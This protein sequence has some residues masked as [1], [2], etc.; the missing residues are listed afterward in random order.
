MGQVHNELTRGL[1]SAALTAALGVAKGRGGLERFG[2]TLQPTVNLWERPEWAFLR[3]EQL[4][5]VRQ[6]QGAVAGEL[7]HVAIANPVDSN[8]ISVITALEIRGPVAAAVLNL[9]LFYRGTWTSSAARG[10]MALQAALP[11]STDTRVQPSGVVRTEVWSGSDVASQ[12][13]AQTIDFAS[14]ITGNQWLAMMAPPIVLLPDSAVIFI[15]T[16]ANQELGVRAR[17]Y[18]RTILNGELV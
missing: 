12:G 4:W 10:T 7:S 2:E 1:F 13:G 5:A 11:R 16:T 3:Q 6:L 15:N 9:S 18:E 8:I 17:G 14:V